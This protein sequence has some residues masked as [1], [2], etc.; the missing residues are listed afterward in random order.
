MQPIMYTLDPRSIHSR[1]ERSRVS[2][3]IIHQKLDR[4]RGKGLV[5]ES[6]LVSILEWEN[7]VL[8]EW[9]GCEAASDEMGDGISSDCVCKRA[10]LVEERG[11]G[12]SYHVRGLD[13]GSDSRIG[14]L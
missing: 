2:L 1:E 13:S 8:D 11:R 5:R 3:E 9:L 12:E 10:V 4:L 7:E 6:R 14:E